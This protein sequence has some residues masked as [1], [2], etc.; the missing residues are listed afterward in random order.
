MR[1][2]FIVDGFN[3]YHSIR[4]AEKLVPT[5]PQRWLDPSS[6]CR[7]YLHHFGRSASLQGI[8]Y[9]SALVRHLA[10]SNHDIEAR[11]TAYIDA[12]RSTGVQVTLGSFKARDKYVPLKYCRFRIWA[13]EAAG[14]DS[15][16]T[17]QCDLHSRGGEGNGRRDRI[18][19]VR[20]AAPAGG[21]RHRAHQRRHRS[22]AGDSH[23]AL[24]SRSRESRS[25]SR[26]IATTLS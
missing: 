26:T 6:L 25:C 16:P 10:A 3:L 24:S 5:R 19:Y 15:H 12:I 1:V 2:A 4:D 9:F 13:M 8:Y 23:P 17:V 20:A 11:H 22:A 21:R 18:P 7:S 14:P